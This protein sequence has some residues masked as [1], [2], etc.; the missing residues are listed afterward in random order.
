MGKIGL[1]T[2][3]YIIHVDISIEGTVDRPDVIGAI[4]G[5]TEGLLGSD[6]ELRELQRNGK[7]GRIEVN[8]KTAAGKAHGEI[9]IPSS[10]DKTET[11]IIAAALETIERIGPCNANVAAKSIEDVRI[12]KRT[13]VINRA[14]E[15]LKE[16]THNTL[17]DTQ[18]ITEEV[19]KSVRMTEIVE[20]GPEKL[21]AGPAVKDSDEIIIVEGRADVLTL[22]KNGFKNGIALNGTSIPKTIA[23]L[24]KIKTATL[25]VDGDRGGDLIIRELKAIGDVDFVVK[26]PDGKEVEELTK[27]EINKALRSR[28]S[29]EQTKIEL[30]API[31]RKKPIPNRL[32]KKVSTY[33]KPIQK[34]TTSPK[35]ESKLSKKD[36]ETYAKMLDDLMGTRGAYILDEEQNVLGKVPTSELN[37]T[38]K[39]LKTGI[40][41]IVFDGVVNRDLIKIAERSEIKNII[42]M[43][44]KIPRTQTKI[45]IL[46]KENL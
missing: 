6:L 13:A 14:K 35:Y 31:S 45:K 9:L 2:A 26:A 30:K 42:A 38:V 34:P 16:L 7:I 12:S 24:T 46:T 20:F 32:Q 22:L 28:V 29:M 3:K 27:K 1:V 5:Q 15:L 39:N 44:S 18:E 36:T 40:N 19:S 11:A 21:A 41:T 10:L 4:F 25:F 17:P 8:L 23:E 43:D 37:T 33:T